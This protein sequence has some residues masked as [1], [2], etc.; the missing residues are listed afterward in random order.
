VIDENHAHYLGRERVEMLAVFPRSLLLVQ[1]PK[2]EFM[3]EGGGLKNI[4]ISFSSHI[5]GSYFP[6]VRVDK[7]HQ[8]VEGRWL[9]VSP[10]R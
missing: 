10:F 2:I 3:D 6:E 7:R 8:L 1:E 4:G 5:G 9:A